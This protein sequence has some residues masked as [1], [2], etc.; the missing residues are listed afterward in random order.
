MTFD[1]QYIQER[2]TD[3]LNK[4]N[5]EIQLLENIYDS[6]KADARMRILNE[7][8]HF[9]EMLAF[10]MINQD[11]EITVLKEQLSR[12]NLRVTALLSISERTTLRANAAQAVTA[13]YKSKFDYYRRETDEWLKK[14]LGEDYPIHAELIQL[15]NKEKLAA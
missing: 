15:M 1:F 2:I 14:E 9:L 12:A 8:S 11:E 10:F 6:P 5:S 4:V 13:L 3:K 7:N